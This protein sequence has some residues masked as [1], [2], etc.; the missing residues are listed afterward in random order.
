MY[1]A[2]DVIQNS[3]KKGPEYGREFLKVLLKSFEHIGECSFT[4]EK[5]LG[6]LSR[7]LNIWEERGVYDAKTVREFRAAMQRT[8]GSG[9][10][11]GAGSTAAATAALAAISATAL[12]GT[13]STDDDP[14][15]NGSESNE[16]VSVKRK[17]TADAATSGKRRKGS[18][19]DKLET[20][21]EVNGA[22]ETHVVLNLLEPAGRFI[23]WHYQCLLNCD[24]PKMHSLLQA[25]RQSRRN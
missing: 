20:T 24:L 11:G 19:V 15:S 25:I 1:L 4:D 6:S 14:N 18:S 7:I 10:I 22:V 9:V 16:G 13:P 12:G 23:V 17:P 8:G 2:N 21:V 3:K 5:T